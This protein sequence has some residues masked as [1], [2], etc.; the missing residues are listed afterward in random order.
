[1]EHRIHET[2]DTGQVQIGHQTITGWIDDVPCKDCGTPRVYHDTYD[3]F[4]CP[5]CN[6][7]LESACSDPSCSYCTG[8]PDPPLGDDGSA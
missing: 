2:E 3:A 5:A 6:Q 8:R 7:W 4:F 1:V